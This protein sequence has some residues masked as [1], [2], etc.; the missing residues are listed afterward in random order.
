MDTDCLNFTEDLSGVPGAEE[1]IDQIEGY[2]YKSALA[3][4]EKLRKELVKDHE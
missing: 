1:L 3:A 4:L 2:Q